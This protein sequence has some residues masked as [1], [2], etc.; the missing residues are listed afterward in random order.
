MSGTSLIAAILAGM[1][2]ILVTGGAGY[3]GRALVHAAAGRGIDVV[4]TWHTTRAADVRARWI[5]LDV[6]HREAVREAAAEARPDVVVH[7]AYAPGGDALRP[8]SVDGA[9]HVATAAREIGARLVHLSTDVVFDGA[10]EGAYTEADEA[11]PVT[12]YGR[13][14]LDAERLVVAADPSALVARTSLL[15]GGAEPGP[16]ERLVLGALD[17]A[18]VTFFTDEL[19][20]PVRVDDLAEALLDLAPLDAAGPLH[21]AGADVVS[22]AELAARIALVHR[23]DPSRVRT[24]PSPGGDRPRNCALDSSRAFALLGREL[25]GP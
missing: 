14:K 12:D 16:Q 21:V 11:R 3:L 8:V 15:W 20:C 6:T 22:R 23:C 17:G 19:R 10:K 7:T 25:P 13:A 4:A 18:D 9:V 2:R 1:Q 24:G 5:R